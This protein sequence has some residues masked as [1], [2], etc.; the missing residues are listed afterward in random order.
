MHYERIETTNDISGAKFS[1]SDEDSEP[2]NKKRTKTKSD[3]GKN[4]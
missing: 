1:A 4:A 3:H 2:R